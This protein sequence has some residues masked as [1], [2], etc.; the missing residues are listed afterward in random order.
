MSNKEEKKIVT[1]KKPVKLSNL[2]KLKDIKLLCKT[3]AQ[4]EIISVWD[5]GENDWEQ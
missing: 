4:D 3:T 1:E 2:N 5:W